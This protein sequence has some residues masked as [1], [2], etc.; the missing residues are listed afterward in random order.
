MRDCG[1]SASKHIYQGS[2]FLDD[3][4]ITGY[5][6]TKF[7]AVVLEEQILC[8]FEDLKRGLFSR[9]MLQM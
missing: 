5:F 4:P 7:N 6:D 2:I 1:E 9:V 3:C 8:K